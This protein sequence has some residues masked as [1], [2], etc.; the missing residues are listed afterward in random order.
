MAAITLT[1]QN[2]NIALK[3]LLEKK[4]EI[5]IEY[6]SQLGDAAFDYAYMKE[7]KIPKWLK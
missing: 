7:Y 6:F 2:S 4:H 5:K 3:L 1:N